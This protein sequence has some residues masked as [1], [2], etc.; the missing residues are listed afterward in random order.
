A[1]PHHPRARDRDDRPP[2]VRRLAADRGEEHGRVR[3]RRGR[4][5]LHPRAPP[6]PGRARRLR[7]PGG[8]AAAGARRL[9]H[10]VHRHHAPRPPRSGRTG[11][12][13]GGVTTTGHLHLAVALDGAGWHPAAWREAGAHA[14]ELFTARYWATLAGEAERGLLDFVTIEDA[15]RLQSTLPDDVDDR[16]D[17]VRGRLDAVLLAASLAPRTR[18]IGPVPT[19]TTTPTEPFHVAMGIAT[20]DHVSRGRAGWGVQVSPRASEAAHVGRRAIPR[21]DPEFRERA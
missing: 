1:E 12:E 4:G 14:R 3:R 15:F 2:V 16:T 8:A 18:H 13:G 5:R 9:P 17:Q 20:L 11:R 19:A 10:R 7:R 6:H 21:L